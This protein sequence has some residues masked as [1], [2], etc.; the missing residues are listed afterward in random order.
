[1]IPKKMPTSINLK[2]KLLMSD[3]LKNLANEKI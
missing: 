1:M 3:G 2:V